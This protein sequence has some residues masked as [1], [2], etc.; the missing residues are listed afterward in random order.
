MRL[1]EPSSRPQRLV[2]LAALL[3]LAGC[4]S[5]AEHPA[6]PL[7]PVGA[8]DA[9]GVRRLHHEVI[10]G[11]IDSP[12]GD[13][14]LAV[15]RW[16]EWTALKQH[17]PLGWD[18]EPD[19]DRST[20][21]YVAASGTSGD[22][23]Q[24]DSV[25]VEGGLLSAQSDRRV[26]VGGEVV[27]AYTVEEPGTGCARRPASTVPYAVLVIGA[28]FDQEVVFTEARETYSCEGDGDPGPQ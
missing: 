25:Y 5:L 14:A 17:L 3:G 7:P 6:P 9:Q 15:H 26:L 4:V 18:R 24:L 21:L 12:L 19:L 13:A 23:V 1:A 27:V 22:R 16:D 10:A 8:P 2:T 11:G 28:T 20:V